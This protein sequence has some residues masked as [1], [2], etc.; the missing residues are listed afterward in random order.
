MPPAVKSPSS[1]ETDRVFLPG[2]RLLAVALSTGLMILCLLFGTAALWAYELPEDVSESLKSSKINDR[3][4]AVDYLK[5]DYS[6]EAG[7]I[8][9]ALRDG[10]LF[11]DRAS[12]AFYIKEESAYLSLTDFQPVDAAGLEL[13][14]VGVNNRQ[15]RDLVSILNSRSLKHPDARVRMAASRS[16]ISEAAVDVALVRELKASESERRVVL[17]YEKILSAAALRNPETPPLE[18]IAALNFL[19]QNLTPEAE[20]LVRAEVKSDD[21]EVRAAASRAL[22]L[23]EAKSSHL[24]LLETLFFGLSLG[25]VLV[26]I[27]LGLAITFGVMGVINMAHGEMVMLGAYSVWFLQRQLPGSPGL[28]LLLA[29]PFS[30]L[31]AGA[32][33]ALIERGVIRHLYK[34]PLETLLAT[35]GISLILQQTVRTYIASNNRPVVV[36]SFLSGQLQLTEHFSVTYSRL[37]IIVFC[38]AVFFLVYFVTRKTRMGLEVRA[39]TQNRDIARALGVNSSKV[40]CRTFI[41]GSGVA[42]MAGVALSQLTNVGPNLGQ[43]YI[44]DSFMVVVFGGVGNLWGTL[45][46]GLI[47]G[48]AN[49]FL[50]SVSGA[51]MAKIL[52]FFGIILF[53]QRHPSGLFPQKGRAGAL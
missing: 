8:L 45:I 4:K 47:L 50:E 53:I 32:V 40:D 25:S 41:L 35:F 3:Q 15:R 49:M 21:P 7:R 38:L 33:G 28:A 27:G 37:W 52:I 48:M 44:V 46:G 29:V 36:P 31:L 11:L 22:S 18:R 12:G 2:A 24:R 6:E 20:E 5:E 13:K 1:P 51:M 14:T 23:M 16:L 19:G 10:D 30:F 9:E 26:L 17:N 42:G 43:Q 39:V 34:R